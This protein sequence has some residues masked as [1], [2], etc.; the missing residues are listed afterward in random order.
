MKKVYKF[1]MNVKQDDNNKL[2]RNYLCN[3]GIKYKEGILLVFEIPE[4][5]ALFYELK[6]LLLKLNLYK[7]QIRLEYSKEELNSSKYFDLWLKTYSG[8]P[9]P[10]CMD[11]DDSY[12]NFTYDITN[13]CKHCGS[14]LIQKD[15]FYLKPTINFKK[16]QFGGI[17]WVYDTF[18]ITSDLYELMKNEN[19]KGVDFIPVKNYKTKQFI[20]GI[21]QLKIKTIFPSKINYAINKVS[22]CEYCKQRKILIQNDSE[23]SVSDKLEKS[24][25]MDFYLSQELNGDGLLCSRRVIISNRVYKFLKTN[26]IKNIC[27]QPVEIESLQAQ[28][29]KSDWL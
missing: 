16:V 10:E 8:Y 6:E 18:F 1:I 5:N 28:N 12:I 9:Q 27:V 24:L 15:S 3:H 4:D 25:D 29:I 23:I 21:V 14:G 13:F 2:V 19:F 22:E 17:Y 7:P 20:D 11:T 26:N